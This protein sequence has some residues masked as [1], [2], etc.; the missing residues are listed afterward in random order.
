V[1]TQRKAWMISLPTYFLS[2]VGSDAVEGRDNLV[3]LLVADLDLGW[4]G[5]LAQVCA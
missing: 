3:R 5:S 1:R 2:V 4:V